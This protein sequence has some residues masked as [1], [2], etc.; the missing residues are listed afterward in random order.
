MKFA[1][2][3]VLAALAI[4][5][6][7]AD[8]CSFGC[9]DVYDPVTDESGKTYSNE[10]YMRLAKCQAGETT[11]S[12]TAPPATSAPSSSGS[13]SVAVGEN[14]PD[15][16]LDVY[17]PVTDES[18]KTYSNECYM[19]QAKCQEKKTDPAMDPA[20]TLR[21]FDN[22]KNNNPATDPALTLRNID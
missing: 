15:A 22:N 16:C 8:D 10:C 14:C 3:L 5:S 18:G 21:N 17:D 1:T 9:L 7:T 20:L 11:P 4:A 12:T 6:A 13:S 2:C 19:R